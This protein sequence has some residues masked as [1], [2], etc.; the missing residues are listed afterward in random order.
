MEVRTEMFCQY[1]DIVLGE[2]DEGMVH[3][4]VISLRG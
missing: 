4:K 3:S 2:M 1:L